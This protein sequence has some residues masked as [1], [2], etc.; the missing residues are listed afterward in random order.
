MSRSTADI[1]NSLLDRQRI[2]TTAIEMARVPCPQTELYDREP[3]ILRAIREYF[4]P[5]FEDAG[6]DTFV[7]DYGNLVA[8]Q[9]TG[10]QGKTVMFL[11]YAME[12]AEATMPNPWSGEVM[13]GTPF[14]VDGEVV[15]GRGGSEWRP[16]NIGMLECA[17]I[18]KESGI[19]IPGKIVYVMS[20]GGHT[21]SSDPVYHLLYNDQITADLC[22]TPGTKEI[23]LGNCGR[24]DLRVNVLGKSVHSGGELSAGSNAIE[25]GL[26]AL[27]RIGPIM[28]YSDVRP[29]D[30]EMGKGR[31]S[32]IGLA[33]Y[34][35]SPGYHNGVGSG[36][37]TL[38]NRMR[39]LLDR[40]LIPGESVEAAIDEIKSAVG[41]LSPFK[42]TFERGAMQYP[43]KHERDS[44]IISTVAAAY[45]QALGQEPDYRYVDYTIDAGYMNRAGIPT[46]MFGAIDM[47]YCHG[48]TEFTN[49]ADT[50]DVANVYTNWAIDNAR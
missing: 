17:R 8:S 28:P 47:R 43:S 38:Q 9:G 30:P 2:R 14:G 46:V 21:S 40:R 32:I 33:S 4:R 39:F 20:S 6:C 13:D 45:L 16:T 11:S 41:D 23:V 37:H 24:L 34:P 26:E 15:W 1:V 18:I 36:G 50:Y 19:E 12:W 27:R 42:I 3:Q 48:D 49:L 10:R 29:V 7:D 22:I 35:F 5:Q 31:L 44:E 25:G